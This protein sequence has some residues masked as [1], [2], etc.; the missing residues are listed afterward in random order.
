MGNSLNPKVRRRQKQERT[1]L[2]ELGGD[3][4][5]AV[6]EQAGGLELGDQARQAVLCGGVAREL[7]HY[8][9]DLEPRGL[10]LHH[11]PHLPHHRSG[12]A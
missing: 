7:G 8:D 9:A 2:D 4:A 11:R 12:G 10:L 5:D 3:A 1:D 6:D